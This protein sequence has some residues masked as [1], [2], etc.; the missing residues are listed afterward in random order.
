MMLRY[1]FESYTVLQNVREGLRLRARFRPT[2]HT[3]H[4]MDR[5][6]LLLVLVIWHLGRALAGPC[7]EF[8]KQ[9]KANGEDGEKQTARPLRSTESWLGLRMSS[10]STSEAIHT[11]RGNRDG[12]GPP[13]WSRRTGSPIRHSRGRTINVLRLSRLVLPLGE[14]GGKKISLSWSSTDAMCLD[15]GRQVR[16]KKGGSEGGVDPPS[17]IGSWAREDG[18]RE[19]T[20]YARYLSNC[21]LGCRLSSI[22]IRLFFC[23]GSVPVS[24]LYD[25]TELVDHDVE[26]LVA[27]LR[28]RLRLLGPCRDSRPPRHGEIGSSLQPVERWWR[29]RPAWQRRHTG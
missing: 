11:G 15:Q 6:P 29:R 3:S 23:T 21:G 28:L 13:R 25:H 1:S 10:T 27:G 26:G 17:G 24:I 5:L 9:E 20:D 16:R 2:R 14:H 18:E 7:S 19:T 12:L 22:I 4:A 8:P